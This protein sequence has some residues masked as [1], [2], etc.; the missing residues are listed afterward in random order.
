MPKRQALITCLSKIGAEGGTRTRTDFST[1]PSN[2]R[3]YQLRHL[4]LF[5]IAGKK[6]LIRVSCSLCRISRVRCARVGNRFAHRPR[7]SNLL[8]CVPTKM[9]SPNPQ[10]SSITVLSSYESELRPEVTPLPPNSHSN[11]LNHNPV[12]RSV[13]LHS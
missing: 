4:S 5:S 1:R 2:V 12:P 7:S 13:T 8:I 10:H 6:L 11:L 3:G 9:K